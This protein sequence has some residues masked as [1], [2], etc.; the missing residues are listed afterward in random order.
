MELENIKL[1]I[2]D[3]DG[4]IA[5]LYEPQLYPQAAEFFRL[6]GAA[7]AD[8]RSVPA[9]ALA[10]NQGGPAMR[11]WMESE[12]F[13]SPSSY[14]T[15]AQVQARLDV[16]VA[17]IPPP[18]RLYVAYAYQSSKGVWSPTPPEWAGDP[19]WSRQWRKPNPGML[20]QAAA[21][22]G[23]GETA[24]LFVGDTETDE[25]AAAA[26]GCAFVTA[27]AFW[28]LVPALISLW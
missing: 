24:V 12:G 18:A 19:A 22:H 17:Q 23:V 1:L 26:A 2:F 11:Y 14:P 3:V 20:L 28:T 9:I 16:V 25:Q 15:L 8:G 5:P 6:W 4:T 27:E 7:R 13:G 10:T 21:D